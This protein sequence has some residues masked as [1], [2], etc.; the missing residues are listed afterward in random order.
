MRGDWFVTPHAVQR[1]RE[2][3]AHEMTYEQAWEFL[4]AQSKTARYVKEWKPGVFLFRGPRP[5]RLRYWVGFEE[6]RQPQLI[7]VMGGHDPGYRH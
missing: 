7:T 2:R 3:F 1:F 5:K 6:G 4:I